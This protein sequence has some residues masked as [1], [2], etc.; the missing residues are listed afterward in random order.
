MAV[1][2]TKPEVAK[3]CVARVMVMV[4]EE[5]CEES[6]KGSRARSCSNEMRDHVMELRV[7]DDGM[8]V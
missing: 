2:L 5:L 7:R 1:L 8:A 4:S 6:C 3:G